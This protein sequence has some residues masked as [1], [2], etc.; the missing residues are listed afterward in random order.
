MDEPHTTVVSILDFEFM[1]NNQGTWLVSVLLPC[2]LSLLF[3]NFP[4]THK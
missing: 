3:I 2:L 1:E 4:P